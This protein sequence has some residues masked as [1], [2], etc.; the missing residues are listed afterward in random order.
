[1]PSAP[2]QPAWMPRG[3]GPWPPAR[4]RPKSPRRPPES[5][6]LPRLPAQ[7]VLAPIEHLTYKELVGYDEAVRSVR[8]LGLGMQKD[9]EFQQLVRQLNVRHGLDRMPACDAL[10]IRSPARE[11]AN[12]FMM[13]T[14]AELGLPV[15]RMRM[16]ENMQ[17]MPVL[18]VMAQADRQPKLNQARNAFEEPA[19]LVIEDIDLWAAP[20]LRSAR[21]YRRDDH[22]R[23]FARRARGGQPYP[24][25]GR[26]PGRV[27]AVHL[28]AR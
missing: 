25:L 18:C 7:P 21:G 4:R 22:V 11:D 13:A 23:A 16:E 3:S 27:R 14:C 2:D 8:S 6:R 9:P 10:L 28:G 5:P 19:V 17:G 1:M 24:L 26:R 15:L 12:Q 20:G